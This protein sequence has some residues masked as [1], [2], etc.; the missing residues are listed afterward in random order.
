MAETI[1]LPAA[2]DLHVHFREPSTNKSET[3]KSGS[4]AAMLGGFALV[5]DMPNNPGSPTW[6]YDRINEK[7]EIARRDGWVKTA[8]YAGSQPESDNVGELERMSRLAI[9]LKLYGDPTTGNENTYY[10]DDFDEI[11]REWH[12]V[13]PEKPIMFHAGAGNLE[14]MIDLVADEHGHPFHVCHVHN[15]EQVH[16][17]G[18]AKKYGLPVTCGVCP[19]HLLLTSHDVHSHGPFAEMMPPLEPQDEAEKLLDHLNERRIDAVESDFAPHSVEAK[20]KAENEGGHCYGVPGIEHIMPILMYQVKKGRMTAERLVEVTSK[21]PADILG[22]KLG[23]NT[24]ATWDV[25]KGAYRLNDSDVEAGCEWSPYT[26]MMAY[27][28]MQKLNLGGRVVYDER[29]YPATP[30]RQVISKRGSVI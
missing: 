25:S 22:V 26:G 30:S 16:L 3:I 2:V 11:V 13:A 20:L 8:F 18:D 28:V 24:K 4:R 5:A 6:T 17:V 7:V 10:A 9:G 27:G 1:V 14:E 19:H 23:K 21:K 12:R 29:Q 15:T